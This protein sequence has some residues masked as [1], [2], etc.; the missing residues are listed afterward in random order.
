MAGLDSMSEPVTK[1]VQTH[2]EPLAPLNP[3]EPLNTLETIGW[4]GY[5][6]YNEFWK[7]LTGS[8][9]LTKITDQ[10]LIL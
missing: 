3:L 6:E 7:L 8:K 1:Y 9:P 2:L 4:K 10:L 5:R